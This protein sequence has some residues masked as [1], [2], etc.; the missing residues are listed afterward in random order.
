MFRSKIEIGKQ[1]VVHTTTEPGTSAKDA[2]Q[3]RRKERK[4]KKEKR[5]RKTGGKKG[6]RR[7]KVRN[8][9]EKGNYMPIVDSDLAIGLVVGAHHEQR[10]VRRI[11]RRISRRRIRR[12][13]RKFSF[14]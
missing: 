10:I 11:S 8:K 14:R 9:E 3:G 4:R 1:F 6:K 13:I 12:S 2:S 7:N 5:E